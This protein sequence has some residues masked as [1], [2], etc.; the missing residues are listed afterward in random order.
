MKTINHSNMA[1]T[2]TQLQSGIRYHAIHTGARDVLEFRLVS[3][4]RRP[5]SPPMDLHIPIGYV[6]GRER[7][8]AGEDVW[9]TRDG[10]KLHIAS[11]GQK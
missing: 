9:I 1:L 10:P 8:V 11:V 2:F 5:M 3:V 6:V 4:N 7:F